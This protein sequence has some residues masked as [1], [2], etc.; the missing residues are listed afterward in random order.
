MSG[1]CTLLKR[2]A[3]KTV[4][5]VAACTIIAVAFTAAEG[6]SLAIAIR[7]RR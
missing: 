4:E 7:K 2:I 3:L 1:S 5:L 6:I